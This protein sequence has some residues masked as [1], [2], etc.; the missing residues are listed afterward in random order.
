[1]TPRPGRSF[2]SLFQRP[3]NSNKR[4]EHIRLHP[5]SHCSSELWRNRKVMTT[6]SCGVPAIIHIE[7]P[8]SM[9]LKASKIENRPLAK[10]AASLEHIENGSLGARCGQHPNHL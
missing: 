6:I 9:Q 4:H 10:L 3:R 8:Y 7:Q 1:M 2:Y 5:P